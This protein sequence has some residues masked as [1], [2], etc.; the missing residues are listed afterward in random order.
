MVC[1]GGSGPS[2]IPLLLGLLATVAK[3]GAAFA[4]R[5]RGVLLPLA[6]PQP[7]RAVALT[8]PFG[9]IC[10]APTWSVAS[11]RSSAFLLLVDKFIFHMDFWLPSFQMIRKLVEEVSPEFMMRNVL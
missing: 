1:L 5:Y 9:V 4:Q 6:S 2:H 8:D 10:H 3:W 11:P 7:E